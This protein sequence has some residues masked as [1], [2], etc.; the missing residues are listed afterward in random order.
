[1]YVRDKS[2]PT[3]ALT[4]TQ[5]ENG[6]LFIAGQIAMVISHPSEYAVMIDKAKKATGKD[7]ELADQI[8]ANMAY[9]PMPLG[10][11]RR[12]VVFGGWNLH[13]FNDQYAGHAVDQ[14]AVKA[15][16]AFMCGPEWS[17]KLAWTGSNPGNLDGFKTTWMKE[18]L[19]T[20]KFLDVTT[21]MLPYG[22]PFPVI[23]ESTSIMNLI[24][25]EMMQNALTEKMTVKQ[26]ADDAAA[27]IK[28]IISERKLRGPWFVA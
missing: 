17:T 27:K 4:N 24:V 26:A 21:S 9:G 6:D 22:I 5:T 14:N 23:P 13:I 20:I 25:P 7:K 2:V 28:K 18:R 10:P 3:S 16:T 19:D 8:V 15:L 12:A 1:M 11:V